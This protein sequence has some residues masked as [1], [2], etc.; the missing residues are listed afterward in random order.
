MKEEYKEYLE[1]LKQRLVETKDEMSAV[2]I[3]LKISRLEKLN[4]LKK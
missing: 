1:K 3:Q 2:V 4:S